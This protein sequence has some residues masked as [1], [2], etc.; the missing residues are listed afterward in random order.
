MRKLFIL[1]TAITLLGM[2][3]CES[4]LSSIDERS[5]NSD[6]INLR[7]KGEGECISGDFSMDQ[8]MMRFDDDEAFDQTLNFLNCASFDE[9]HDWRNFHP[10]E[11]SMKSYLAFKDATAYGKINSFEELEAIEQEFEG[12]II[13]DIDEKVMERSHHLEYNFLSEILDTDG[14]FQIGDDMIRVDDGRMIRVYKTTRTEI[15]DMD[16]KAPP[17]ETDDPIPG[18]VVESEDIELRGGPDCCP[19]SDRKEQFYNRDNDLYKLSINYHILQRNTRRRI[20]YINGKKITQNRVKLYGRFGVRHD[21]RKSFAFGLWTYWGSDDTDLSL[22][23][24]FK[25]HYT[26]EIYTDNGTEDIEGYIEKSDFISQTDVPRITTARSGGALFTLNNYK[27]ITFCI[28]EV[29]VI[30]KDTKKNETA[31]L[32]CPPDPNEVAMP[33]IIFYEDNDLGGDVVCALDLDPATGYI[34]F[35]DFAPC[36]NDEARSARLLNMRA[37]MRLRVFDN[38]E[39]K[40]DDDFTIINIKRDFAS[41]G[42]NSF[43]KSTD[44]NDMRVDYFEDNG[45][46]GKISSFID[47]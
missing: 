42:I 8:G 14:L 18:D 29:E 13:L 46:D 23:Y 34:D 37:G 9:I 3:G 2:I 44:D 16:M 35:T 11:T 22:D 33:S 5:E 24:S 17:V 43:E 39:M 7:D 12:K 30:G 10:V 20:R 27:T 19:G 41:R 21:K 15:L 32:L 36:A 4:E 1:F 28:E 6:S 38:S 26:G 31:T 45:L 25:I 47:N 40:L